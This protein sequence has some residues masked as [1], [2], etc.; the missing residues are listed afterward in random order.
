MSK[1]MKNHT[2][3]ERRWTVSYVC[4]AW[5]AELG[6]G[7]IQ[8]I[9]GPMQPYLA[10]NLQVDTST[11]NL[12]WTLGFLGFL[13]GSLFTSHIFTKR[14]IHSWQK[15]SFMSFIL[16]LTGISTI[17][18]P[19]MANLGLLL[20]CRF[21]QFLGYGIFLTADSILLV[22]SLGPEKSRPFINALH[23]FI[24]IGF[25]MGTF[26]VQPFLPPSSDKVCAASLNNNPGDFLNQTY[27]KPELNIKEK[28]PPVNATDIPDVDIQII[29]LIYG[30]QSITWP[31]LISGGWCLL[32]SMG[33]LILGRSTFNMPQFY[34]ENTNTKHKDTGPSKLP[35]LKKHIFLAMVVL[36]FALSGGIVRVFQSM[37]MTFGMCGPL[38]LESHKAALT[39]SFYS[40]GMCIGR[41]GSIVL[42]TRL[43]PSTILASCMVACFMGTLLLILLAPIYHI[44]LYIGV[45]I[46]GFFVSWQFGTGFSWTSH[47]MNITGRLSSIFFIGLG[48]GSLSSP[49]LAG[50]LF[51]LEPLNVM[52]L[53]LLMVIFQIM[54]VTIMWGTTRG[55]TCFS[56][57]RRK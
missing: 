6:N 36:F 26:L 34:D 56:N 23:F 14:L 35:K 40:C 30:M 22:F 42:A 8:T 37:S 10:Y 41:L 29:P 57:Q 50:W 18:M 3:S 47:H 20:C 9:T 24:S 13:L 21:V 16:F 31:F 52:Y 11:I 48:V 17:L 27:N 28:F 1:Y 7:A 39:D 33:F 43:A 12:V 53:L 15:L 38:R 45:G 44:S 32:V 55:F 19:L 25:L 49:P 46:M 2:A 54:T 51:T 4:L 5:L